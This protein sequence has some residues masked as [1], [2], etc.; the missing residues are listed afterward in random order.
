MKSL[1]RRLS[2]AG[3]AYPLALALIDRGGIHQLIL[4]LRRWDMGKPSVARLLAAPR[5]A[6][7]YPPDH[8]LNPAGNSAIGLNA[9]RAEFQ[10]RATVAVWQHGWRTNS[11]SR[12]A[13]RRHSARCAARGRIRKPGTLRQ[14]PVAGHRASAVRSGGHDNP[15]G[16]A[17]QTSSRE[18]VAR[19]STA[20]RKP[21]CTTGRVNTAAWMCRRPNGCGC[22]KTRTA[23]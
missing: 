11:A 9:G 14:E 1:R 13:G 17:R 21:P 16:G 19:A 15:E 22:S 23:S 20:S 2:L 10:M 12:W 18:G 3:A 4:W 6:R 5:I 8:V 7:P